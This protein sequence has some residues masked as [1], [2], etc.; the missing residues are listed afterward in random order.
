MS[1]ETNRKSSLLLILDGLRFVQDA[2]VP[3]H[4]LERLLEGRLLPR[5]AAIAPPI[6]PWRIAGST[7]RLIRLASGASYD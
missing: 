2:Q 3:I 5:R 7:T 6:I 1:S 4:F